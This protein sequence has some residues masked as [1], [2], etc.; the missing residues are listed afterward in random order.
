MASNINGEC[1]EELRENLAKGLEFPKEAVI[2][3]FNC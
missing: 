3:V 2:Y 1:E